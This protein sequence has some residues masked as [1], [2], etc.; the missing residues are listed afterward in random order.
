MANPVHPGTLLP[1]TP[2]DDPQML[3]GDKQETRLRT[4]LTMLQQSGSVSVEELRDKFDVSVVT[5]RRDLNVLEERGLLR[6]T[7]GGAESIEPL[8]YEPFRNDRSF[9]AQVS[10]FAD[11][12]RRIGR[13]AAALVG[14]GET[15]ALTPGTTTTEVVRGLPLNQNITVVTNTVNIA[16]ELSKR[17]DI[18]VFVTGGYL[19]GD[20]FSLLGPTAIHA[21]G[22]IVI[23]TMF[24][25][26][27]GIDNSWGV[28]C[29]S[30]DEAALNE[31]MVK[32]AQ[33]KVAVVDHSK[34]GAV[35]GWRIC[36]SV[37]L[38]ILITDVGATDEMIAPFESMGIR[39]MR[40]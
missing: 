34:F 4:I 1:G 38:D 23:K 27:D 18:S 14:H 7:H 2:A 20:W 36:Q 15:V 17:K 30:P 11:E 37:D 19:R 31:T 25:G 33:R 22:Q 6:R 35:A 3:R 12:K 13:A 9:Q 40:V 28:T 29:F 26:A 32:H 21:L 16:M 10:R 5:V 8:F 24:I 39:V